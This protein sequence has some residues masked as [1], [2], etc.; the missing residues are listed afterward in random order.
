MVAAYA[1]REDERIQAAL[2]TS[3]GELFRV[4][5]DAPKMDE[6]KGC[7]QG[8]QPG[9]LPDLAQMISM[10]VDCQKNGLFYVVRAWGWNSGSWLL[11]RGFIEGSTEYDDVWIKLGKFQDREYGGMRIVR[12]FVDSGYRPGDR[13]TRPDNVIYKFSRTYGGWL[14]PIKGHDQQDK[15][16]RA[17][18]I[19]VAVTGKAMKYGL[20]LWHV[21]TNY[22]KTWIYG[23]MRNWPD[24]QEGGWNLFMGI[25]DDYLQQVTSEQKIVKPS[26]RILWTLVKKGRANHFLDCEVYAAACASSLNVHN[27]PR[28]IVRKKEEEKREQPSSQPKKRFIQKSKKRWI[29][30]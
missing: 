19:D 7:I 15:P 4:Q 16:V 2:N 24:E 20:K 6:V 12:C 28:K 8:Y 18:Q 25:D 11:E 5:G 9:N 29:D 17:S 13:F 3:C 27:L 21:D 22:Y 10:G 30:R 1:S 26:G 23:R 14:Y